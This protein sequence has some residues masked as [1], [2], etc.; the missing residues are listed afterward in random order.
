MPKELVPKSRKVVDARNEPPIS[1]DRRFRAEQYL[2]IEKWY[3][4]QT[5]QICEWDDILSVMSLLIS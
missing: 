3:E 1:K 5:G 2:S 4:A